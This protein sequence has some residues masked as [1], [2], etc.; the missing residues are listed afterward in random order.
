MRNLSNCNNDAAFAVAATERADVDTDPLQ[1]VA[2]GGSGTMIPYRFR[3]VECITVSCGGRDGPTRHTT[4]GSLGGPVVQK[5]LSRRGKSRLTRLAD[6]A[7]ARRGREPH[8]GPRLRSAF[9]AGEG[10]GTS[11]AVGPR[12]GPG[13]QA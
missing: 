9:D 4:V 11:G 3:F 12:R 7:T 6:A 13:S 2:A 10:A 1:C 8:S 5:I